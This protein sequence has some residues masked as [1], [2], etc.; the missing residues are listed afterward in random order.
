MNGVKNACFEF[1]SFEY[2][3]KEP[4]TQAAITEGNGWGIGSLITT[5]SSRALGFA[6]PFC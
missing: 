6:L 4:G 1:G 5:S 3:E 2:W